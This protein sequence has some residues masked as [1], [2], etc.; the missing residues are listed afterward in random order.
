M[1]RQTPYEIRGI[2]GTPVSHEQAAAIIAEHW[3]VPAE[4]R[5][6]RRN[7][8]AGGPPSDHNRIASTGRPS[9]HSI[10]NP[11]HATGQPASTK[12]RLTPDSG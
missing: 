7:K 6:R 11:S 4:V 8:K 5:A 12:S 2:D 3:T 10:V 9:P 1:K